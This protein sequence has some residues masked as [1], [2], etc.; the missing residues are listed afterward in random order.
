MDANQ[1][2]KSGEHGLEP[3]GSKQATGRLVCMGWAAVVLVGSLKCM[4]GSGQ[5]VEAERSRKRQDKSHQGET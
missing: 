2:G 4:A 3:E 1:E 5:G